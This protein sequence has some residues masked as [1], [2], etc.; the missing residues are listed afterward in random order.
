MLFSIAGL[1]IWVFF[2]DPTAGD[3]YL[4]Q[5]SSPCADWELQIR[6]Y[7]L[8]QGFGELF[9]GQQCYGVSSILSEKNSAATLY[10]P[11]LQ[12]FPLFQV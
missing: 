8:V 12:H 2:F 4:E 6:R 1:F 10:L 7:H 9:Q 3:A 5:L 11:K